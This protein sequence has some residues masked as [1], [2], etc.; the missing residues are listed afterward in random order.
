MKIIIGNDH[1]GYQ[2]KVELV[3]FVKKYY[4]IRLEDAGSYSEE[5]A[6]YPD[7]AHKVASAVAEG[8]AQLGIL[9]CGSG[10]GVC[11]TANKHKGIRAALAW[12][13]ELATL[14]RTHNAANVLCLPARYITTQEAEL[15]VSAFLGSE[16]E[17]G[18]HQARVEKIEAV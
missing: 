16:P 2:L 3:H 10:N 1:A 13:P 14:A 12:L 15:M 7:F 17:G 9:V 8:R 6:D 4:D 5:R 11:I 18:R